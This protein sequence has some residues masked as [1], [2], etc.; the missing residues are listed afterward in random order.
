[1][2]FLVLP[3]VSDLGSPWLGLNGG[4]G[5]ASAVGLWDSLIYIG[6]LDL[7]FGSPAPSGL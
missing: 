6:Y 4:L 7:G 3:F 1:M 2:T 5:A